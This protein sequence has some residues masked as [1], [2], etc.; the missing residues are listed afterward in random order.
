[1][2]PN[3]TITQDSPAWVAF[4]QA[5]FV[6]AISAMCAGI[7][8]LPVEGWMRGYL[9]MGLF[10]VVSATVVMSKTLRDRHESRKIVSKIQEA[11]TERILTDYEMPRR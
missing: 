4:T 1:M 2:E 9:A 5:S 10:F 6:I 11:K 8:Y 3:P 7:Y